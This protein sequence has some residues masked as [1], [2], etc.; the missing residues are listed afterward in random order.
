MSLIK[1][2]FVDFGHFKLDIPR[3]S[4]SD[5]GIVAIVGPSGSGKT[6]FLRVL[7][8]L[9]RCTSFSW[10]FR[11][12]DLVK[13]S[14]EKRQ[15]GFVFQDSDIFPHM[16]VEQNMK[17]AGKPRHKLKESLNTIFKHLVEILEIAHL[18]KQKAIHLS[19]GERQR[20]AIANAL[21]SL[22]KAL[23]LDEP[24][25][26]LDEKRHDTAI[27][28]I[29]KVSMDFDIPVI[30]VTHNKKDIEQFANQAITLSD[31]KV[32]NNN[33]IKRFP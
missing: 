17:F 23:L 32:V 5:K 6:T 28:L 19:G 30:M 7:L 15:L 20:L 26:S 4:L 24:F 1:N 33:E 14:L 9:Q 10:G 29:K 2:I 16:T 22:P 12:E 25:S 11:G 13:I 27:S 18:L 3:L 21:M 8:G 31:G